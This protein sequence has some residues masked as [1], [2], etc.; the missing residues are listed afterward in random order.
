MQ[1]DK[2]LSGRPWLGTPI[3]HCQE[4]YYFEVLSS[5]I[6]IDRSVPK[7]GRE[8]TREYMKGIVTGRTP[9]EG[10]ET[11]TYLKRKILGSVAV[12]KF[13]LDTV[14]QT[15]IFFATKNGI[16]DS[17]NYNNSWV[18]AEKWNTLENGTHWIISIFSPALGILHQSLV[19]LI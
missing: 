1:R 11:Q 14:T 8:N 17:E 19:L 13:A 18:C 10:K 16:K 9:S 7:H 5:T 3:R 2:L 15:I 4:R 12:V 6:L